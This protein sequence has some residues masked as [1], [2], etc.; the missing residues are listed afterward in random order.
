LNVKLLW[1][2]HFHCG[3]PSAAGANFRLDERRQLSARA[4]KLR[5]CEGRRNDQ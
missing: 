2:P 3:T 1:K 5:Q 4:A